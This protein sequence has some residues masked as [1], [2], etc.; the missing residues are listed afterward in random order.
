VTPG[1]QHTRFSRTVRALRASTAALLCCAS[2]AVIVL[3]T[4][5]AS[6]LTLPE[7]PGSPETLINSWKQNVESG[8][9]TTPLPEITLAQLSQTTGISEIE[10]ITTLEG[11]HACQPEG[12]QLCGILRT[13]AGTVN[14]LLTQLEGHGVQTAEV[15]QTIERF[16][17]GAVGEVSREATPG[18]SSS[19]G[20]A[21]GSGAKGHF[22]VLSI[23]VTKAGRIHE[24]IELPG[25]GALRLSAQERRVA[26]SRRAH[27][28]RSHHARTIKTQVATLAMHAA[29]GIVTVVL[30][31]KMV[32]RAAHLVIATTFVPSG[33]RGSTLRRTVLVRRA[34]ARHARHH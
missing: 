1:A 5:S 19:G 31:P 24:R 4:S 25:P 26:H 9:P 11:L 32:T 34:T 8:T 16:V 6:A 22:S 18:G 28:S 20:S 27:A 13:V 7:L 10:L 3:P 2:S 17:L 12:V 23:V 33:G 21:G 29:G 30:N 15:R 14:E